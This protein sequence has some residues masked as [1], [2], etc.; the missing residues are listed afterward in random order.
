MTSVLITDNAAFMRVRMTNLLVDE[1]FAVFQAR[2]GMQAVEMYRDFKPDI[3]LINLNSTNADGLSSIISIRQMDPKA[4]L[5]VL[6]S[7]G[8][9]AELI[10]AIQMGASDFIVKP[11]NQQCLFHKLHH[12][13]Q[14]GV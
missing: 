10:E 2:S 8:Q 7:I 4:K 6:S 9:E 12:L 1:G 13:E 11:I 3:V 14:V 5:I